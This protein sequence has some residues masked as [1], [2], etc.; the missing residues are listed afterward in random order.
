[1]TEPG[2]GALFDI[3]SQPLA[4]LIKGLIPKCTFDVTPY[5][6]L[7]ECLTDPAVREMG[8]LRADLPTLNTRPDPWWSRLIEVQKSL[9]PDQQQ[10]FDNLFKD[11]MG[12]P[13]AN[14]HLKKGFIEIFTRIADLEFLM[15][16][17]QGRPAEVVS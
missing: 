12:Y 9:K 5:P 10:E 14:L 11:A 2:F 6:K 13:K 15:E 4:D 17:L 7:K 1:L 3:H 16:S 8:K